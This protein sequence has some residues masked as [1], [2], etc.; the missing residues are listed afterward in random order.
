MYPIVNKVSFSDND[1]N[2]GQTVYSIELIIF[3]VDDPNFYD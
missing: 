1:K 2:N 3:R